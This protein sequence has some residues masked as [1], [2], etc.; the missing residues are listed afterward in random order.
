M[1]WQKSGKRSPFPFKGR[2]ISNFQSISKEEKKYQSDLKNIFFDELKNNRP[3]I[4]KDLYE[5]F[6]DIL[7]PYLNK[8]VFLAA[9]FGYLDFI[10]YG[11]KMGANLNYIHKSDDTGNSNLHN[12]ACYGRLETVQFFIENGLSIDMKNYYGETAL[13][14]AKVWNHLEVTN[15]LLSK[16]KSVIDSVTQYGGMNK[17]HLFETKCSCPWNHALYYCC[18]SFFLEV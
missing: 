9:G 2:K 7:Q 5:E 14:L 6:S 17:F 10:R 4:A 18:Q 1:S 3:D 15:Y 8:A 13:D 12:A 11:Q 16:S